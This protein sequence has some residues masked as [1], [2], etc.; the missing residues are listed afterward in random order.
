M[1]T[2]YLTLSAFRASGPLAGGDTYILRDTGSL[3]ATLSA[4]EIAA[5]A[6][7]GLSAMDASDDV[8]GLSAAQRGALGALALTAGDAVTLRDT[9]SNLAALTPAEI[10]VLAGAGFDRIDATDDRLSLTLAQV[11]S[12][13]GVVLAT[14]DLASITDV[15]GT[16]AALTPTEIAAVLAAGIDG[17]EASHG[18]LALDAAQ[19][20]ALGAVPLL[21]DYAQ[22]RDGTT[23]LVNVA[24]GYGLAV[25][26]VPADA[27]FALLDA[28][29]AISRYWVTDGASAIAAGLG[30]MALATKL[31]G[32]SPIDNATLAITAAQFSA[33]TPAMAKLPS[34]Y[35]LTISGATVAQAASLQANAH[36]EAFGISDTGA[37]VAAGLGGLAGLGKLT[38]ITLAPGGVLALTHAQWLAEAATLALLPEGQALSVAGVPVADAAAAQADAR[39]SGF[40]ILDSAAHVAAAL[41]ALGGFDH[42]TGIALSAAAPLAIGFAQLTTAAG[43]LALL[44]VGAT[45][46]VSDV[47]PANLA[48]MQADAR[49]TSFALRGASAD[50]AAAFD[51]LNG[52]GKLSAITLTDGDALALTH[53]QFI[54]DTAA[55]AKLPGG[56]TLALRGV[57]AASA[58]S[59]QANTHVVEFAVTDTPVGIV[60]CFDALI[61]ATKLSAVALTGGVTLTISHAQL[62]A[63]G[64][65]FARL[66]SEYQLQVTGVPIAAGLVVQDNDHVLGFAVSDT[67]AAIASGFDALNGMASLTGIGVTGGGVIALTQARFLADGRAV[68]LLQAGTTVAVSAAPVAEAAALQAHAKVSAFAVSGSVAEVTAALDM[69]GAAGKLT[70]ITLTT[71]GTFAISHAQWGTL[72]GTLALLP[73]DYTVTVA[74]APAASAAALQADAHVLGFTISDGGA[75][76]AAALDALNGAGKLDAISLADSTPLAIS[77]GS[78]LADTHALALLPGEARLVVSAASAA[79]AAAL[80]A[81]ARVSGF[82]VRDTAAHIA[83]GFDALDDAGKLTAVTLSDSAAIVLT[84]AQVASGTTALALVPA[85]ATLVLRAATTVLDLDASAVAALAG[86]GVDRLL[87]A[88][89]VMSLSGAQFDALGAVALTA[90]DTVTLADTGAHL[91][92][93]STGQLAGLAAAGIDRIDATDGAYAFSRAQILALGALP[94]DAADALVLADGGDAIASLTT[95]QLSALTALGV[96]RIDATDDQLG[97]S[98]AQLNALGRIPLT[99]GDMV[100]LEDTAAN[101]NNRDLR[102]YAHVDLVVLDDSPGAQRVIGSSGNDVIYA[103]TQADV[104][105]E[106]VGGGIDTIRTSAS[107]YLYANVENLV[108]RIG[109]GNIFGV[110]NAGDNALTGNEANNLLIGLDGADTIAGDSGNDILYG[111]EGNDRMSGDAGVDFVA[112]GNGAD[113][114]E[115][116]AGADNLFGEAGNDSLVDGSDFVTDILTGGD[117][118]DTL[119]AA[120]GLGDYDLIDG[121]AGDDRYLVDTPAD[122]TFEAAGGG[123]D[124]VYANINGGGCYLYA[125]VENLVLLGATPFGVG[126]AMA[127]VL[128]GSAGANWLLGGAGADTLAGMGGNDVLFGEA[129]RDLFVFGRACAAGVIGDFTPGNDQID[130]RGLGFA[131]FAALGAVMVEVAGTTAINLGQGD[132]IIINGVAKAALAASDFLLA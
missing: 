123:I 35:R 4:T 19:V 75:G 36:V 90:A 113:T 74:G 91:A 78:Y 127:N 25:S 56:Y 43:V 57:P 67:A 119:D 99:P 72:A 48:A 101:A 109:A 82:A 98:I 63:G 17:I 120:S 59:I 47:P 27:D 64:S 33:A 81:D 15:P 80:Q 115:G 9:A 89:G 114:V 129:G 100:T 124:T 30:A 121:G 69:L 51:A 84:Q 41:D 10:A 3:L 65:L 22:W 87:A 26:G 14:D 102:V 83:A 42:L 105:F 104:L 103:D 34:G 68:G 79:G 96:D 53:A 39:V 97:L 112:G 49:V 44:P 8:L 60:A 38:A 50:V 126:N 86:Q 16:L 28:D 24:P 71:P 23:A 55:L 107:F 29:A 18:D 130:L 117:G 54:A 131:S 13:G 125:N 66:P 85:S 76:V 93:L 40:T 61:G 116:G 118:A 94:K 2:V 73:P 32:I 6:P 77:H 58:A 128:T 70:G 12:L 122:L 37:H 95:S 108:L 132:I 20:A 31:G 5:L 106:A 1:A 46:V 92:A 45:L 111:V 110:G 88:S 52:A 11:A 7:A 21:I 62:L